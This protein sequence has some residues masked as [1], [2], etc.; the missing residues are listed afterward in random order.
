MSAGQ[1]GRRC[2]RAIG[3]HLEPGARLAICCGV[4]QVYFV[5]SK[6]APVKADAGGVTPKVALDVVLVWRY[7]PVTAGLLKWPADS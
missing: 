3:V 4:E 2:S 6:R 7:R 5:Q 1:L